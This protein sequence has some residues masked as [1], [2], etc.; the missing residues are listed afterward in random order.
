MRLSKGLRDERGA[1]LAR[2]LTGIVLL[3][4]ISLLIWL[5][6]AAPFFAA[7]VILLAGVAAREY[8]AVARARGA[9]PEDWGVLLG[10]AALILNAYAATRFSQ[11]LVF[12]AG[13][14][15]IAALHLF[16][17]RHTL[18]GLAASVFGLVYV[19]LLPATLLSLHGF[20]PDGPGLVTFV[21]VAVGLADSGAYFAGS[22]FGRHKLAPR[23]S[24]K[25]SWEGVAGGLAAALAGAAVF[26]VIQR[27]TGWDALPAWTLERYLVTA[28]LLAAASVAGDLVASMLKRDAGVKDF[29]ALFP[30][31]GGVLDR[32]DGYLFAGPVLFH[33]VSAA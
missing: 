12:T 32:C 30:G 4:T 3:A 8:L 25:K 27:Q 26:Y 11:E 9:D 13:V 33:L 16:R 15:V 22:A 6:G 20:A 19:G 29:G 14:L 17:G 10:C 23:V 18:P 21:I 7:A 28:A 1:L 5:P 24:P 2:V 31:H